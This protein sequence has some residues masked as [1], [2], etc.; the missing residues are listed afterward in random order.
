VLDKAVMIAQS[1]NERPIYTSPGLLLVKPSKT[2]AGTIIVSVLIAMQL[3]GLGILV[4]YIFSA[5]VDD[6]A[7]CADRKGGGRGRDTAAG[8]GE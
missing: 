3:V 7:G 2:L 8:A 4:W 6:I 5:D 1:F